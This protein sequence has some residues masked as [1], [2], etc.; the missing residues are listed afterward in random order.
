MKSLLLSIV[1][2]VH[3]VVFARVYL[4]RRRFYS[5]LFVIGFLL[6]LAFNTIE[7]WESLGAE[8]AVPAFVDYLRWAGIAFCAAGLPLFLAHVIRYLR[9]RFRHGASL[10]SKDS[11]H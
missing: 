10:D 7:F 8:G 4:T 3:A 5:L 9:A 11:E 6:L 1:F 2:A